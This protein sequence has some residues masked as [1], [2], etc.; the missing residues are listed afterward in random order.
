[1]AGRSGAHDSG[2]ALADRHVLI[3]GASS[4]I[5]RASAL[6]LAERGA[7][8]FTLARRRDELDDVVRQVTASGG[9]AHAFACDVTDADAVAETVAD[10]LAR[11]GHVDFLVNNAGRSIRRS[12]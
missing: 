11:F 3:T 2:D 1:M 4:G 9:R 7:V 6:A 8:V 5:G 12:V 10:I